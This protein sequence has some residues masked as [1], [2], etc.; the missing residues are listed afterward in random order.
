MEKLFYISDKQIEVFEKGIKKIEKMNKK[1][2]GY[3]K[4]QIKGTEV[5]EVKRDGKKIKVR[6]NKVIVEYDVPRIDGYEIVAVLERIGKNKNFVNLIQDTPIPKK[7]ETS[8]P[9]CEHCHTKRNRKHLMVLKDSKGNHIQIG[10]TCLKDFTVSMWTPEN[11]MSY[12]ANLDEVLDT[13]LYL[14][15]PYVEQLHEI[16]GIMEKALQQIKDDGKYVKTGWETDY[17]Q[18][19]AYKVKNGLVKKVTQETKNEVQE[20]IEKVLSVE[21]ETG[22]FLGNCSTIIEEGLVGDSKINMLIGLTAFYFNHKNKPK[23][24]TKVESKWLGEISDKIVFVPQD[25]RKYT[26]DTMY[27]EMNIY[28][29]KDED[30]NT[31]VWKTGKDMDDDE[32]KGKNVRGTVKKHDTFRGHK[33]TVVY[34]CKVLD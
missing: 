23:Q 28:N 30:G 9:Y 31:L 16:E 15:N 3:I 33:Q 22:S 5:I 1:L 12:Y 17:E 13:E 10:K 8:E 2:G 24:E 4:Y 14:N 7:Y 20:I 32:L 19:T 29:M 21:H 26:F 27:G 6:M 18:T 34:R 25:I 11:V